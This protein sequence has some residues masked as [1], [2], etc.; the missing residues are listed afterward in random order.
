M[1]LVDR[2]RLAALLH[3][4]D[5]VLGVYLFGSL[6]RGRAAPRSDVDLAV[7]LTADHP[8]RRGLELQGTLRPAVSPR[9]LDLVILN[10]AP[11]SLAYRVIRDG[12]LLVGADRAEVAHHREEVVRRYLDL[13][14]LRRAL[15]DGLRDRVL[16][17]RF[18]R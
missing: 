5:D 17:G 14:P 10:D 15:R 7:L 9:R 11:P 2:S 13:A 8:P 12:T 6:A 18:G 1:E 4:Q 3:Q 16:E